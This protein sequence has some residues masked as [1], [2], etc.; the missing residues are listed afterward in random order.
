MPF[1]PEPFKPVVTECPFLAQPCGQGDVQ[2]FE[3]R[4]RVM[5]DEVAS[6][7]RFRNDAIVYC[8]VCQREITVS[9]IPRSQMRPSKI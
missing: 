7:A 9:S 6:L 2:G 5:Q 3:C 8:E 1:S 4:R